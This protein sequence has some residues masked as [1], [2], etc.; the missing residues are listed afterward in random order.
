MVTAPRGVCRGL[1]SERGGPRGGAWEGQ[2]RV[3]RSVCTREGRRRGGAAAE[4]GRGRGEAAL[5]SPP[6]AAPGPRTQCRSTRR[7]GGAGGGGCSRC[8]HSRALRS[9]RGWALQPL[10]GRGP[11]GEVTSASHLLTA[12]EPQ[13]VRPFFGGVPTR[14]Y[15]AE[16]TQL[17]HLEGRPRLARAC[18]LSCTYNWTVRTP[19]GRA[20]PQPGSLRAEESSGEVA[21][22]SGGCCLDFPR[23]GSALKRTPG[24][25]S[26]PRHW[27]TG[28]RNA[29]RIW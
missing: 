4:A 8:A 28:R 19:G 14:G 15:Q 11:C 18:S 7:E 21:E 2:G 9:R 25:A 29:P 22:N 23:S 26:G 12:G 13:H 16:G 20:C 10:T 24:A 17:C 6:R 5:C 1:V 3:G 27:M